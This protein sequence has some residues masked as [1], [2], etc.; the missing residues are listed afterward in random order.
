MAAPYWTQ[1]LP[2]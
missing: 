2:A 1:P